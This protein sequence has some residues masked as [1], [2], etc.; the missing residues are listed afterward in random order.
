MPFGIS[1]A[2]EIF[3]Q[4]LNKAIDDLEGV[5]TVADDILI[6]GNG[7]TLEEATADHDLKI[8]RLFERCRTKQIKLNSSK[9]EFKKTSMTYIGHILTPDGV[10]ADPTKVKAILE[11][12]QPSDVAG[13]RRTVGTVNYLAKFL[14]HLSQV[15]EPL[16]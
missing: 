8:K 11:M 13:V 14:P 10:K 4:R 15:S 7:A 12:K 6:S 5:R 3:Q 9:I 16:R 2:G 1:P